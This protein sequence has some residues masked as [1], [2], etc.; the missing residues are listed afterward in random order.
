M[1][2]PKR[3]LCFFLFF[4]SFIP[5]IFFA[6]RFCFR[7]IDCELEIQTAFSIPLESINEKW[8]K[9]VIGGGSAGPCFS[10]RIDATVCVL[11]AENHSHSYSCIRVFLGD[12]SHYSTRVCPGSMFARGRSPIQTSLIASRKCVQTSVR[13]ISCPRL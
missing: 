10:T 3:S 8:A 12:G 11:T 1:C 9:S 13:I 2:S 5:C 4:F 7:I 6:F